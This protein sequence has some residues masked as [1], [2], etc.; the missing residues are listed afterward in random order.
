[1]LSAKSSAAQR[2]CLIEDDPDVLA[3]MTNYLT[4]AGLRVRGVTTAN[5]FLKLWEWVPD[6]DCIITDVRLPG[7]DG[8]ALLREIRTRNRTLPV[9]V[10]TGHGD[11]DM[12]VEAMKAGATDFIQKPLDPVHLKQA[13][14]EAV[15]S[16]LRPDKLEER[17]LELR[18]RICQLSDRQR[19]ILDL[20]SQGMTSKEIAKVLNLSFRT[21]ESHR[22]SI[23]DQLNAN[24]LADL[25]RMII[26][27]DMNPTSH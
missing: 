3:A 20:V 13:I 18:G 7:M 26:I 21:V 10:I 11:V 6:I 22:A 15:S 9:I 19:S 12:A 5:E 24:T 16:R 1:M 14:N 2:I 23:M 4:G 17:K 25:I 8:I 27:A